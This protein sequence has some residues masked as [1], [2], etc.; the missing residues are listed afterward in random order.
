M[1]KVKTRKLSSVQ[2]LT[3]PATKKEILKN[4]K[5]SV[6]AMMRILAASKEDTETKEKLANMLIFILNILDIEGEK[7]VFNELRTQKQKRAGR[8]LSQ[9]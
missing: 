3:P 9:D 2:R 7:L 5:S 8:V 6:V 1:K 4:S